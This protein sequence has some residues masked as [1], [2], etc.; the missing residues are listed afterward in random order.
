MA[1]YEACK[2]KGD[3]RVGA[4]I[5][6]GRKHLLERNRALIKRRRLKVDEL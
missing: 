5:D 6:D 1:E 4:G 2:N 3:G